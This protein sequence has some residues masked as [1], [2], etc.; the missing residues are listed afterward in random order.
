MKIPLNR[1]DELTGVGLKKSSQ[2]SSNFGYSFDSSRP[3]KRAST[4]K[5]G[6]RFP[7]QVCVVCVAF[8]S[9][10]IKSVKTSLISIIC[11]RFYLRF[12]VCFFPTLTGAET[13]AAVKSG[14]QFLISRYHVNAISKR[15]RR[16]YCAL[17]YVT[18]PRTPPKPISPEPSAPSG[19]RGRVWKSR[20]PKTEQSV[21]SRPIAVETSAS[22]LIACLNPNAKSCSDG[23]SR[24]FNHA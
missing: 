16:N 21:L 2:E 12:R 1:Q 24:G 20:S 15:L 4:R 14:A 5:P 3:G 17:G 18:K 9:A 7:H 19:R 22:T 10:S 11:A 23:D 13:P 6:S 8:F